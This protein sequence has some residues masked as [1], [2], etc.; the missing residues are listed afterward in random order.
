MALRKNSQAE[1]MQ[2]SVWV[3]VVHESHT[4][5]CGSVGAQDEEARGISKGGTSEPGGGVFII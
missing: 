1:K 5:A 2:R 4:C 3:L